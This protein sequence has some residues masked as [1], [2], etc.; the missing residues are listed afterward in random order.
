MTG[1]RIDRS[2]VGPVWRTERLSIRLH[3]RGM[4]VCA[5]LVLCLVV[6]AAALLAT[7]RMAISPREV[8]TALVG[9]SLDEG[10][11]AI[12]MDV[13]LPRLAT[14]L[15]VGAALGVSGAIFQSVS[16][17]P[18]GSPDVIGFTTGSATGAISWIVLVGQNAFGVALAAVGGG[19]AAAVIV[20]LLAL[21]GGGIGGQRLVLIGVGV[22]AALSAVNGLLLSQA[23][24]DGAVLANLWLAGSLAGRTWVHA[25]P[26]IVTVV[27]L[28][29]F[30][31]MISRPLAL[32][33]MGDD[34]ARQV[35]VKVER[36]RLVAICIGMLL[37][38]A[39]TGAAGPIA[40]IALAAPQLATRLTRSHAI[41]VVTSAMLG[42]S[43]IL[44]SDL[45]AQSLPLK[46]TL[47]IGRMTSLVGGLYFIWLLG[48]RRVL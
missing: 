44:V 30:S 22:G 4:A 20:Y 39:A 41:L 19:V 31:I 17:N 47:P 46:A 3:P 2:I 40:F 26:V 13:R 24:L 21:G 5:G 43:L 45:I 23:R 1:V 15:F 8:F 16:R 38:G 7:G 12:V 27:I 42:A 14:G 33:E 34:L 18:L 29:P 11:R 48:R 9:G 32:I 6:L 28:A 37:A 36:T 35:G 25:L 10:L